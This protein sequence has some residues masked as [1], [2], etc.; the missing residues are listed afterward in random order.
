MFRTLTILHQTVNSGR[1]LLKLFSW[2]AQ[3]TDRD[4]NLVHS[5]YRRYLVPFRGALAVA[6]ALLFLASALQ[7]A[8]PLL[9]GLVIDKVLV[10]REYELLRGIVI[11][12]I[13]STFA[14]LTANFLRSCLLMKV[15][16]H[17]ALRMR[18]DLV[19]QLHRL[20]FTYSREK[21]SG[22]LAARVL[23]DPVTVY[24]FMTDNILTIVQDAV[25][26]TVAL[27][28]MLWLNWKLAIVSLVG[29]PVYLG[30]GARY[31]NRLRDQNT[32]VKETSAQL[33]RVLMETL[34][35]LYTTNA[36]LAERHMLRRFFA[37]QK[38]VVRAQMAQFLLHSKISNI[39]SVLT[40]VGPTVVL[41]YGGV[42]VIRGRLSVGELVAFAGI[43]GYLFN[44]AQSLSATQLSFQKVLVALER[45]FQILEAAPAVDAELPGKEVPVLTRG[46]EFRGVC[47]SYEGRR[48]ILREIDL[49]I[50]AKKIVALVGQSGAGKSTIAHLLMRFYDP[51]RGRIF[52]D[53]VELHDI[54]VSAL[55][56]RTG[57]VPQ[58]VFLYSM[59][60]EDNIRFGLSNASSLDVIEA[61]TLADAHKFIQELPKGYSTELGEKGFTLSGGQRQRIGIAR[62]L[63]RKPR[64]LILDEAASAVDGSAERAICYTIHRLNSSRGITAVVIAHR[65]STILQADLIYMIEGG[66]VVGCGNHRNLLKSCPAYHDLI[67]FQYGGT[68]EESRTSP[69]TPVA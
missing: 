1:T 52:L 21:G 65:L 35:G 16:L 42:L 18:Q 37:K 23:D 6:A 49:V 60:V 59:S 15:K 8:T 3:T 34:D 55:R 41:W 56:E 51:Q 48:E 58:D 32:L 47:F 54:A 29:L 36:C 38:E 43:F 66:K 9:T 57:L 61:A 17:V 46:A 67:C 62:A 27:L 30:V 10:N 45:I 11:L 12:L 50:P 33:S 22:Y 28:I 53:D 5:W 14:Y 4:W 63:M 64:I 2:I 39:R 7:L 31:L 20:S 24:G 44:S 68:E 19:R 25:M 69:V 13:V 26:F 40:S